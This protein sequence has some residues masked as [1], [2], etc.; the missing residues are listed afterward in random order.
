MQGIFDPQWVTHFRPTVQTANLATIRITRGLT[1]GYL[2]NTLGWVEPTANVIYE[3]KARW[4][5]VGLN[6]KRDFIED[7]ALFNRVRVVIAF[8]D[9]DAYN[10]AFDGFVA[11]DKI[12]LIVNT[13]NPDSVADAVYYWGDP[14]SS[15]AWHH[16]LNCQQNQ[17]QVG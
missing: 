10:P 4:Q 2:D 17:K 15:N 8:A 11:N 6:T 12:E 3:G 9:M 1:K 14:T 16:T 5:K 7:Y 13:S